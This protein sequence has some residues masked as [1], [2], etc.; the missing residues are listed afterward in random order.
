MAFCAL[1]LPAALNRSKIM[2]RTRLAMTTLCLRFATGT[3][4]EPA[5]LDNEEYA[6][7]LR[8]RH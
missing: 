8:Y 1:S 2:Q 3:N 5:T 7:G 6:F 4:H